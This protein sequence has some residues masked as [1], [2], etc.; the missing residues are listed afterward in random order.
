MISESTI[1]SIYHSIGLLL[2]Y[3]T[4]MQGQITQKL[5]PILSNNPEIAATFLPFQHWIENA[6]LRER[7]EFYTKVF[8]VEP[9]CTPLL[10]VQMYGEEDYRRAEWM[11]RLSE[12][13]E[14]LNFDKGIELPDHIA[15]VVRFSATLKR[16]ER[17][18]LFQVCIAFTLPKMIEKL[19]AANPYRALL[20]TLAMVMAAEEQIEVQY[21]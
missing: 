13:Y 7:E 2:E 20:E 6:D 15:V 21:A 18:D 9:M 16:D 4:E 3:P 17:R 11:V 12:L 8:D 14:T 1:H 5:D 10:S 19:P